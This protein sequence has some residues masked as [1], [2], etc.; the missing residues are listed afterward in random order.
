MI[1][2]R[3]SANRL[4]S[5]IGLA[6]LRAVSSVDLKVHSSLEE[7]P[8]GAWDDIRPDDDPFTSWTFLW[9]LETTGCV[10][11]RHGWQ[12]C[13]LTA[14]D[15]RGLLAAAPAYVK[16]DG[17]GDFSRDWG[18]GEM[19]HQLGS[20]LY[21]KLVIGVPFSPVAGRRLLVRS[22]ED[23]E[24]LGGL[25]LGLACELARQ[26]GLAAVQVLY[27]HPD[28]R[29]VVAAAGFGS[30]ALVQYHWYNY[31]YTSANDWLDRLSSKRRNQARRER[32][33]PSRQGITIRTLRGDEIVSDPAR[34]A[35]LAYR[36]Y[37]T[38]CAKYMWGGT[39]LSRE[40]YRLLFERLPHQVELVIAEAGDRTVAGA[41][42]L[43][44]GGQLYGRYW[45][46]FE[47]HRFLHFNVCLYHSIDECIERG[48]QR[49]EGGAGG[50][51]KVSRGFEPTVA[52]CG[53]WFAEAKVRA[54]IG[55]ALAADADHRQAEVRQWRAEQGLAHRGAPSRDV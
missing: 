15:E 49:F 21:P 47:E 13:H 54:V 16:G 9:A 20:S 27:H 25:L 44:S 35:D 29:G 45:G 6:T 37:A 28:E 46:C 40:F 38:T 3:E 50:E 55:R 1:S 8:Q 24:I 30:R 12:P 32:N 31:G 33:E 26:H 23:R 11:P 5:P 19:L 39:Y 34:W 42:N 53:H 17:M 10:V 43:A 18:L 7:I 48:V 22:G 4:L 52:W 51:H 36:L 41:I 14:W 2:L